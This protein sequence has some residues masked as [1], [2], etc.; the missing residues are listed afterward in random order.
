MKA[1]KHLN[2]RRFLSGLTRGVLVA[3]ALL[4]IDQVARFLSF[5]PAS[6]DGKV[7]PVGKPNDFP[8]GGLTYVPE[9]RTYVGRDAHG[10]YAVDAVCPHLGCLVEPEKDGT[11]VCPC[12]GSRFASD[13]QAEVGPATKPL[14]HLRLWMEND[15]QLMIDRTQPVEQ[16]TRLML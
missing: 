15:G 16:T 7:I 9:A 11:F 3:T 12:H 4:V 14:R 8:F 6:N 5:Q 1:S 10:L 2:R 13:G